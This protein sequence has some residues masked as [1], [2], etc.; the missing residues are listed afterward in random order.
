M[1][2]VK[3]SFL[4]NKGSFINYVMPFWPEIDPLPQ[5]LRSKEFRIDTN[6]SKK[7]DKNT[8]NMINKLVAHIVPKY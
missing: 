7:F 4:S 3:V 1:I 2:A 6:C 5:P 8:L